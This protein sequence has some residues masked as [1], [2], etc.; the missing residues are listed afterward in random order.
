M[1]DQGHRRNL[2]PTVSIDPDQL[3]YV[4]SYALQILLLNQITTKLEQQVRK[5]NLQLGQVGLGPPRLGE[6]GGGDLGP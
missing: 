6:L 3:Q 4:P 2:P 1:P 5:K